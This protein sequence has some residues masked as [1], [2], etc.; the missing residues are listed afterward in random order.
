MPARPGLRVWPQPACSALLCQPAQ[1]ALCS[2]T[3]FMQHGV[4]EMRL[5]IG[6]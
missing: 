2:A 6:I 5:R 3:Y 1:P 4:E